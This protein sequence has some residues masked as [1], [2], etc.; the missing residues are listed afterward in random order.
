MIFVAAIARW[1]RPNALSASDSGSLKC[2]RGESLLLPHCF[3]LEQHGPL[4]HTEPLWKFL[5]SVHSPSESISTDGYIKEF[6]LPLSRWETKRDLVSSISW[7][8]FRKGMLC[9]IKPRSAIVLLKMW[10][11]HLRP[12]SWLDQMCLGEFFV[13]R[14]LILIPC[15]GEGRK[16]KLGKVSWAV[17]AKKEMEGLS[18][19]A[20]LCEIR[21]FSTCAF[22]VC[23][24]R[25][26]FL[27]VESK[28]WVRECLS[29]DT[30]H[31]LAGENW[32]RVKST[33][34]PNCHS[35]RD[36]CPWHNSSKPLRLPS[37]FC[38]YGPP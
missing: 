8:L 31:C 27:P 3:Q 17:W 7:G 16:A 4:C 38:C 11:Q 12:D 18:R 1:N 21:P 5:D 9:L 2:R 30:F 37:P 13:V 28:R 23:E 6:T 15:F 19:R 22:L 20:Y 33:R 32:T 10:E 36:C 24:L 14:F 25:T 29:S 26:Y 35:S 34:N